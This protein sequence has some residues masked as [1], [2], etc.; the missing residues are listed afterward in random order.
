[1]ARVHEV[2]SACGLAGA[3]PGERD[4][5][6]FRR[7]EDGRWSRLEAR[8]G[9]RVEQTSVKCAVD[10]DAVYDGL[11]LQAGQAVRDREVLLAA[12]GALAAAQLA[13]RPLPR[14]RRDA[15]RH[16][17][18]KKFLIYGFAG[19]VVEVL[20]TG[21]TSALLSKDRAATAKTYLWMHPIYGLTALGMEWLGGGMKKRGVPRVLRGVVY[22]SLI[23]AAE[24]SSGWALKKVLGKCPWDYSGCGR[25]IHGLVR[26][27]YAPAWYT[28][29]MLFEPLADSMAP[30]PPRPRLPSMWKRA[31]RR[32]GLVSALLS[33]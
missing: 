8:P 31:P 16:R 30:P 5:E 27:D 10:V 26:L 9:G 11:Q 18:L 2:G 3:T 13:P 25:D 19:W 32:K 24:Y 29:G 28:L 7:A 1:M 15:Q 12:S 4:T 6:V 22:T 20:F 23:Y 33:A 17:V 21:T 14:W